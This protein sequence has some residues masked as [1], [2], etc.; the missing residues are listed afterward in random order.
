[1]TS[2]RWY[3]LYSRL[4]GL[5]CPADRV[6]DRRCDHRDRGH[7]DKIARDEGNHTGKDADG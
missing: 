7:L 3:M 5:R 2:V 1:M 6:L 4:I